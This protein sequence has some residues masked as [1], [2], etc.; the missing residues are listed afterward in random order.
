VIVACSTLCFGKYPFERALQTIAELG[1]N[2]VDVAIH[3]EGPH[4]KPSDVAADVHTVASRL[5][6]GPGLTPCAFSVAT[7]EAGTEHFAAVCRLARLTSV[8]VVTIAAAAAGTGLDA[9]LRRLKELGAVAG[10]EGVMLTVATLGG[11]LT[12]T[13]EAAVELCKRLPWL[14]LTLDPSHY[15]AGSHAGANWEVVYPYVRHVHLRDSGC[16]PNQFQVRIGQGE[17]EYGKI[18]SMLAR[19]H[20]DRVLTVDVRDIPDAPFAMEPEV[21]KLK[22][23]LESL[24]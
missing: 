17:I 15:V 20:Y 23:L 22:Y 13:P 16:G 9:E 19:Y 4:L 11:T 5:R 21:R 7:D 3:E 24:V 14:G 6:L 1:F 2:K 12:E 18:V 8:P 10:R